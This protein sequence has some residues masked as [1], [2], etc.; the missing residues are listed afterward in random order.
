MAMIGTM[1]SSVKNVSAEA[2]SWQRCSWKAL[3]AARRIR[4]YRMPK[5]FCRGRVFARILQMSSWI[6]FFGL[7]IIPVP[8]LSQETVVSNGPFFVYEFQA[9]NVHR[10]C[11]PAKGKPLKLDSDQVGMTGNHSPNRKPRCPY[12]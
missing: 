1:E 4:R 6:N 11:I 8:F 5:A 3:A 2:R 9:R 12:F 7:A 10:M